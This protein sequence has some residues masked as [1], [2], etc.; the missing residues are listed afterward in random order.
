[1]KTTT[2]YLF[3]LFLGIALFST[4]CKK[5]DDRPA[6]P[7]FFSVQDD[8]NLGQQLKAEIAANP[9]EYPLLDEQQYAEAYAIMDTIVRKILNSGKLKYRN[10]FAWEFKIIHNDSI[11]NAFCAPGG[12]IYVYTGLIKY[13]DSEDDLAGVLGHEIAHADLRHTSRQMEKVYGLSLLLEIVA[14]KNSQMLKNI[15][16][17]L[18]SLSFSRSMESEADEFSV[19]YLCPTDY[20]ADGAAN[21]FQKIE[22]AGGVSVPEFLS[23]H[24]SPD[25]RIENIRG[26]KT[27]LGCTGANTYVSRYQRLINALP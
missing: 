11:L 15:A 27:E 14:G 16:L 12:Y 25:K 10:E 17:Q 9:A 13:L 2:R 19:I 22:Q 8:I 3:L 24:P 23:T 6:E 21:F 20:P 4:G 18:A 26:K 5:K 1:M 7:I